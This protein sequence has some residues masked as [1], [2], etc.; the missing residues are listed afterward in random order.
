M[1]KS[2]KI[3][4][5][6]GESIIIELRD[7]EK[8]GFAIRNIDGLGPTKANVNMIELATYDGALD[9]SARLESR[10]IVISLVFLE[11]PTIED[12]R[13]LSY[14]FFPIKRNIHFLIETDNRICETIG[15]VESNEPSIFSQ[16]EGATISLLCPDP[17]FYSNQINKTLLYGVDPLFEF[18]FS[19][20]S[21]TKPLL[22]MGRIKN[23]TEETIWYD[24]DGEVGITIKMDFTGPVRGITFYNSK[25]REFI[26]INDER[27]VAL[28]GEGFHSGDSITISTSKGEKGII[29]LRDGEEINILNSLDRPMNW[30]HLEKGENIFAYTVKEGLI[31]TTCTIENKIAY[32]GV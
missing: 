8:S 26:R 9:G 12:T 6:L 25:T 32:E 20:E 2:I 22:E 24:G 28:I 14:K 18:P 4:N 17:Y 3:T 10:N 30:F 15:R 19:N 23:Y 5:H 1:I 27:L 11:N 21:L 16:M 29:L 7:P 13:L 31:F